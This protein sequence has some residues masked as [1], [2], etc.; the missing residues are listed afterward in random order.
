MQRRL[1]PAAIAALGF[2]ATLAGRSDAA[3]MPPTIRPAGAQAF[4][5]HTLRP[6]GAQ[7]FGK[8]APMPVPQQFMHADL[9]RPIPPA[10]A[11]IARPQGGGFAKKAALDYIFTSDNATGDVN[12]YDEATLTLQAQGFGLAGWGVAADKKGHICWGTLGSS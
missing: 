2:F 7:R 9:G 4:G 11:L 8:T 1:L 6:F 12:V 3:Q 5:A 10:H